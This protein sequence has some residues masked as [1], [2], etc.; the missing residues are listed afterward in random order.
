MH[1]GGLVRRS[2][3]RLLGRWPAALLLLAAATLRAETEPAGKPT[4]P[5]SHDLV[6]QLGDK[7]FLVRQR[8]QRK[9]LE[10]GVPA[11]DALQ[12]ALDN[13]DAEVRYRARQVLEQVLDLDF[14][15]QLE[16]FLASAGDGSGDGLPGW[17]RYRQQVGETHA[18]RRLFV[19]MQRAERDLLQTVAARP[20][21][22]GELLELRCQQLQHEMQAADSNEEQPLGIGSIAAFLFVASNPEVT[23]STQAGSYV[24]NFANQPTLHEALSSGAVV[25][26]LRELL[27][28]WT[29]RSFEDNMVAYQNL[30][31]AMRY[32]LK[33]ALEPAAELAA[34]KEIPA[35][36]RPF[37]ILALG[38]LGDKRQ[39]PALEPLLDDKTEFTLHGRDGHE[40]RTQICDVALAVMIHLS[41]QNLRDYGFDHFSSHPTW[42]F[43][44]GTLGFKS[45]ESREQAMAKWRKWA[46]QAAGVNR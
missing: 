21:S 4:A 30:Q 1:V 31:L 7:S 42:L 33:A 32:N 41:G 8:A 13:P 25:D 45:K 9:L 14:Q 20:S 12:A 43:N 37:A 3:A 26:P 39:L 27:S 18:A 22:A 44:P 46:G 40:V 11:K 35:Q 15:R 24:N 23:I 36:Q 28:V 38:K 17:Q 29:G 2:A 19:D 34:R 6:H 10:M 5:S 16:T